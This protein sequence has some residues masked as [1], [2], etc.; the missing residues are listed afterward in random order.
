MEEVEF[1]MVTFEGEIT[2]NE[3]SRR[4]SSEMKADEGEMLK[5]G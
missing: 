2:L 4:G 1:E 3:N 5:L